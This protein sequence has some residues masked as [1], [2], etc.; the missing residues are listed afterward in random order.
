MITAIDQDRRCC[1]EAA[2]AIPELANKLRVTETRLVLLAPAGLAERLGKL[3]VEQL[4][5]GE[6]AGPSQV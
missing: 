5:L 4:L 6:D 2:G 1:Q 3:M